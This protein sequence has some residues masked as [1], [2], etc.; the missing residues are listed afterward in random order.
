MKKFLLSI[1]I[2]STSTLVII[3]VLFALK[4]QDHYDL[5]MDR[6][7]LVMGDSHT[8]CS[9]DDSIV[10]RSINLSN[11]AEPYV[12]TYIGLR[13]IF[14]G[15]NNVDTLLLSFWRECLSSKSDEFD[16]GW[17]NNLNNKILH[18]REEDISEISLNPMFYFRP[19]FFALV[20]GKYK[21]LGAFNRSKLHKL[22]RDVRLRREDNKGHRPDPQMICKSGMQYKYLLK[23]RELCE[24]NN[25]KLILFSAPTY[26]SDEFYD[27][28]EFESQLKRDLKGFT[29]VNFTD[30]KVPDSCYIDVGHLN[31]E[32]AKIFS[33]HLQENG[34]TS[35][36]EIME[37]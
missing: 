12:C 4:H 17:Q 1:T 18:I 9:F 11:G 31:Y 21:A 29:L 8:E 13:S 26:N 22:E 32:G 14:D 27:Q 25:V 5:P 37:L 16:P 7:I 19:V 28:V 10:S 15:K 6:N 24:A 35:G 23:I 33:R 30:F 36:A 2:L 34:L 3:M 20:D